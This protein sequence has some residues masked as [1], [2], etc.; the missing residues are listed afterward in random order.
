MTKQLTRRSGFLLGFI[1]GAALIQQSAIAQVRQQNNKLAAPPPGEH[2]FYAGHSLMWYVPKQL[3]EVAE[4]AHIKDHV[5]VGEQGIGASRTLQHWQ[6]PDLNNKAKQALSKG[7]VS[8]FVMSPVQFPDEGIEN[9]VKLGLA[10]N[11]N[12]RFVVQL[13]WGGGDI[14]NQDFPKGAWDNVRQK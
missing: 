6:V 8:V 11:P 13:S 4:S 3:G 5:L 7:E 2:V 10:N 12:M 14:D 9:F 1:V